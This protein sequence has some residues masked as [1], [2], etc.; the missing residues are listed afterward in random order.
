MRYQQSWTTGDPV[1]EDCQRNLEATIHQA[2]EHGINHIETARGYGTSEYQLGKVL[3]QLPRDEIIVQTKVW[4]DKDLK[5]FIDRFEESMGYLKLDHL[6]LFGFHGINNE[7]FLEALKICLP[8][9]LKWKEQGRIR[10]I[11]FSTHGPTDVLVKTIETGEMDYINLHWYYI[12]QDN[13]PAIQAATK[14]DM[15]VFI[16]SPNNK[17]GLL[18]NPSEKFKALT[19]PLNPMVFNGLFCLSRPEVHTISCGASKPEDFDVHL[20]TVE[21]LDQAE[22]LV[23]PIEQRLNDEMAKV[24][25][26]EW[27]NTWQEGL[28]KWFATPGEMHIPVILRLR[29]L[30]LAFDMIEYGKMR[31]NLLGKADHWFP[32]NMADKVGDYDLTKCLAQSPH[33][34]VIPGYLKETEELLGGEAVERLQKED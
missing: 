27:A 26:E 20:E 8:T 16:I 18:Y 1:T 33:A 11:G 19:A 14:H 28:P 30:A 15:G 22:D 24:L 13:W 31:Y 34:S 2:L 12:F 9:A 25:G 6:D 10:N 21:L 32:G 7:D 23:G 29:N 4:P 3:P 5:V 17:G